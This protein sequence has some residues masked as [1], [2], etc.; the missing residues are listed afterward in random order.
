MTTTSG[1]TYYQHYEL[2]RRADGAGAPLA[3]H[4]RLLEEL[5]DSPQGRQ[6][7]AEDLRHQRRASL[8]L[9]SGEFASDNLRLTALKD[10]VERVRQAPHRLLREVYGLEV[11]QGDSVLVEEHAEGP[12][13]LDVLRCRGALSAAEVTRLVKLLAPLVDHA[14]AH[15]LEHVELTLP[16]IHLTDPGANGN[17]TQKALL[18]QPLTA[19]PGL[20]LKVNAI[21]F[22]F[23]CA[24]TDGNAAAATQVGNPMPGD[25]RGSHV[26]LL[27]L[28]AYEALGGQRARV[29]ATGRYA[30]VAALG[31]EGNA[32]L[33]RALADGWSSAG[34][35]AR[36]LAASAGDTGPRAP[37][38]EGDPASEARE[39]LPQAAPS[40]TLKRRPLREHRGLHWAL[41][42]GLVV[43]VGLGG[44][45]WHRANRRPRLP[46]TRAQAQW[47]PPPGPSSPASA[48]TG[49]ATPVWDTVLPTAG[50]ELQT[51][52]SPG[53][54]DWVAAEQPA[55]SPIQS[56]PPV[57]TAPAAPAPGTALAMQ[58]LTLP[59]SV[60]SSSPG[61][62]TA[63]RP[64]ESTAERPV[65]EESTDATPRAAVAPAPP[66]SQSPARSDAA[67]L[68]QEDGTATPD[69]LR[70]GG[71]EQLPAT[72]EAIRAQQ[73][74]S[75]AAFTPAALRPKTRGTHGY[76]QRPAPRPQP[77]PKFWQRLFGH[78]EP[79]TA[80]KP[81][82][83]RQ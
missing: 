65:P 5:G 40:N 79:K 19:W 33:R 52:P 42:L 45:A 83:P 66:P 27:G 25:P 67:A 62:S 64:V 20:E 36:Q 35:L 4:Y 59:P 51:P 7:L 1:A 60:A 58:D 71:S 24:P 2:L 69:K 28:L 22:S 80:A 55:P 6:F 12:S 61:P 48:A 77:S 3:E 31:E 29:E 74:D 11:L 54:A 15:R 56:A 13:L 30:P 17:G 57:S 46:A 34:E 23:S 9:L 18:R 68:G 43:L 44:H 49:A 21:G 53:Q 81:G 38:P 41:A 63:E 37:V 10:A 16:G 26:R 39:P 14:R 73:D 32:V 72:P 50:D 78:K 70:E 76:R 75:S 8:L 82:K 47:T